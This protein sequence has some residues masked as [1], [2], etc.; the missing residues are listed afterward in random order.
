MEDGVGCVAYFDSI[1]VCD[2][3][4]PS[5][6]FLTKICHECSSCGSGVGLSTQYKIMFSIISHCTAPVVNMKNNLTFY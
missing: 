3:C 6:A 1:L 5:P 4:F 2:L